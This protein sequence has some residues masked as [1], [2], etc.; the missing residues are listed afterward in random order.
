MIKEFLGIKPRIDSTAYI[1]E[2]AEIIGKVKIG[3]NASVWPGA[4]LR[5]DW[6]E[7]IL[8]ENSNIQDN[9]VVHTNTGSPTTIGK[10]VTIGHGAILHGCTIGNNCLIGM[11]AILLDKCVVEDNT[12]IGAGAIIT[13]KKVIPAGSL[14]LGAPA[15]VIRKLTQEE[16]FQIK[17]A[18]QH[19]IDKISE[20]RKTLR[21]V[22]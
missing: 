20:H 15:K 12:V 18:A 19:Y 6:E 17:E 8:A 22:L 21:R 11:G 5:G 7:I 16:I 14:A 4:V 10:D 13:E 1:Y 3:K 9:V 2:T